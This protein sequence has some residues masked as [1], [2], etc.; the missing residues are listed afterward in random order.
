MRFTESCSR[1]RSSRFTIALCALGLIAAPLA[2]QRAKPADVSAA[3]RIGTLG[4]GIEAAKLLVPHVAVRANLNFGTFDRTGEQSDI[5][6]DFD[7][8]LKAFSALVDFFPGG[9]GSFHLTGGLVTNPMKV[10]LTGK[11]NESGEYTINGNPYAS[12][13]VGTLKGVGEFK[14]A[15]PY[16]GLGFGTPAKKGRI[17]FLFDL[18]AVIGKP[19]VTLSRTGG[20]DVPGLDQDIQDQ[21]EKTQK[22][23]N[24][25]KVYPV[26]QFGLALRF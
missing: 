9:R 13:D 11:P 21:Q 16:L 25:I 4:F 17:A 24:D 20:Q 23:L 22:D 6:Y 2:A 12:S 26:I 1:S 19:K 3:L 10:T 14:S 5:D 7:L 8:K 18:G 15:A